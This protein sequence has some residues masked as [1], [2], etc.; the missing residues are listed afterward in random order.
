MAGRAILT[1]RL[2]A[3][4]QPPFVWDARVPGFG[5]RIYPGGKRMYI[6]QY[7]TR[8]GKQ[9]RP[10]LGLHGAIPLD[11][12]RERA[13]EMYAAVRK[14]RDPVAEEQAG[15]EEQKRNTAES[16]ANAIE[17]VLADFMRRYMRGK[18]HA[19]SYIEDVEAAF[20]NHV[21][22]AWKGR[23]ISKITRK[24]VNALL[25]G[26]FDKGTP[27]Q[28]NRVLAVVRKFFNWSLKQGT[29]DA[30]PAAMVDR[31]G[32]EKERKRVLKDHEIVAVWNACASL[33]YPFGPCF[34][35]MLATGQRE[36]E[37]AHLKWKDIDLTKREWLMEDNKS[38]TPTIVP[39]SSL[40]MEVLAG[41]PPRGPGAYVFGKSG[42]NPIS[43]FSKAKKW[44][45][46][47][48]P[49]L[50]HWVLHDLRRTAA[51]HIGEL[52]VPGVDRFII[53]RILNHADRTVTG[54][55][56]RGAYLQAKRRAL[57]AWGQR[58]TN[59]T[60]PQSEHKVVA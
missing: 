58:L 15:I 14:G 5:C 41:C 36:G 47:L 50:P 28:A 19:P 6:F 9:R 16:K 55:Y 35:L 49:R 8:A 10:S 4:A 25:N 34:R 46:A 29:I 27:I 54:I 33:G 7:R 59:L 44:L 60:A 21:L 31:P 24:D 20:R 17:H 32:S 12:A 52:E 18:K 26:I 37:I 39:L 13:S 40:A 51:T 22:P 23:D 1:E 2:I 43:G 57:E 38:D 11:E 42:N 53:S 45:D 3:E 48:T 56:D 30:N